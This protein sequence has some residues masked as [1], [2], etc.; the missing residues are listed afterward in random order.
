MVIQIHNY[1]TLDIDAVK[2]K[3]IFA[4]K[5][6]GPDYTSAAAATAAAAGYMTDSDQIN[7]KQD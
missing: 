5:N 4:Y 6:L 1:I 3:I 2:F 7:I